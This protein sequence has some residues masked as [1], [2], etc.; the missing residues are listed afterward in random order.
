VQVFSWGENSD[1]RL[2]NWLL[3]HTDASKMR[4]PKEI[5]MLRGEGVVE[6][7]C[8]GFSMWA[9]TSKGVIFVAGIPE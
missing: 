7:A 3:S 4:A 1:G 6:L 9:L 5:Q 8:G 2:G